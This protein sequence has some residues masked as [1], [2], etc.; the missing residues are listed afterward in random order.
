LSRPRATVERTEGDARESERNRVAWNLPHAARPASSKPT[1][2]TPTEWR[3][4]PD[5]T[6]RVAEDG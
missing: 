2:E 6:D 1:H 4:L 5:E 3:E